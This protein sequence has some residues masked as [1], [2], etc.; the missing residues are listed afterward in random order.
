MSFKFTKA[1]I[2]RLL[3]EGKIR[4]ATE[5]AKPKRNPIKSKEQ[6]G[7][8]EKQWMEIVLRKFC[9]E[10]GWTFAAELRFMS[11]R[12]WKFD[13]AIVK[14]KK[15]VSFEYEGIFSEKSRHTTKSGYTGDAKKYNAAGLLGWKVFRYT[16]ENYQ[17]LANDL[18]TI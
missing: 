1:H 3:K 11:T 17:D 13:F 8:K 14:D 7:V 18:K 10:N 6:K 2:E 9:D 5:I 12:R 15:K 4:G 16:A